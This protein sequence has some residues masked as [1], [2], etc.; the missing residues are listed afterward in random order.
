M[1]SVSPYM[2]TFL[3]I[4]DG[5]SARSDLSIYLSNHSDFCARRVRVERIIRGFLAEFVVA[6]VMVDRLF[7]I[8]KELFQD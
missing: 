1:R 6:G 7:L 5:H 8:K 3:A 2:S 4:L